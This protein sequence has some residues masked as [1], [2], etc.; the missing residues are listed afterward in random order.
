MSSQQ[1]K[2]QQVVVRIAERL[3]G[4][5]IDRVQE[6]LELPALTVIPHV[7][8]RYRGVINLRGRVVPVT[9]LRVSLGLQPLAEEL[10][11]TCEM[12]H[13]RQEEHSQLLDE[14]ETAVAENRHFTGETDPHKC[15]FGKW[16][17]SF[18]SPNRQIMVFLE[19]FDQPHRRIHELAAE[20]TVLASQGDID[21]AKRVVAAAKGREFTTLKQ[22]F[23]QL[24][25]MIKK[26]M[27]EVAVLLEHSG[28]EF[29]ISVDEVVA[30]ET[31]LEVDDEHAV[32]ETPEMAGVASGIAKR[33][34]NDLVL[35][36]RIGALSA[37]PQPEVAAESA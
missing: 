17:D 8:D 25:T 6:M 23:A 9:D 7:P 36:L 14:L 29:A 22:L 3:F 27:R 21:G 13:A 31:L 12:L 26:S 18:E 33:T 34:N 15:L 20:A 19:R 2:T 10:D 24:Q 11:Q 35:L 30:V 28:S 5:D 32:L 4:I 16:Y 37:M 1:T